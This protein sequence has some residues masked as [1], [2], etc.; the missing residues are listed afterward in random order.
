MHVGFCDSGINVMVK[1]GMTFADHW[2][3]TSGKRSHLHTL[4]G[5]VDR[6]RKSEHKRIVT[7]LYFSNNLT[8]HMQ[9]KGQYALLVHVRAV[10]TVVRNGLNFVKFNVFPVFTFSSKM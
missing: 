7:T 3:V 9:L 5:S 8:T 4:C 1:S 10:C 2:P 6:D